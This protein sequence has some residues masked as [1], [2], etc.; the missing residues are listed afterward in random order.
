[1]VLVVADKRMKADFFLY[2]IARETPRE[3]P[4]TQVQPESV[5]KRGKGRTKVHCTCRMMARATTKL[6]ARMAALGRCADS[7]RFLCY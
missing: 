2:E 1:M 4:T 6:W 5:N 3:P 7:C